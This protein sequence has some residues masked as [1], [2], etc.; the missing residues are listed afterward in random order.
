MP[1]SDLG[2]V[3]RGAA[4]SAAVDTIVKVLSGYLFRSTTEAD[5]QHAISEL[6]RAHDIEHEREVQLGSRADRID[7]LAGDVGI[8]VKV[9]GGVNEVARQLQRYAQSDRVVHL[10]LATRLR[11][12]E[13][14]FANAKFNG[15]VVRV[16]RLAATG[17]F[18]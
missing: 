10:V 12:H 14:G 9:D 11:R 18:L 13:A 5:L 3:A 17:G 7:F 2:T 15:K 4:M 16:V 8:E 6:L 1:R